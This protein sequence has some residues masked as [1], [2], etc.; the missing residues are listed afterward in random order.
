LKGAIILSER[1]KKAGDIPLW[2]DHL[3]ELSLKTPAGTFVLVGKDTPPILPQR[4]RKEKIPILNTFTLRVE[5][6]NYIYFDLIQGQGSNTSRYAAFLKSPKFPL[7][8]ET[9]CELYLYYTYGEAMPYNLQFRPKDTGSAGFASV[10]VQWLNKDANL[11]CQK[12][13]GG[14]QT[15]S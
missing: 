5:T 6:R 9:E 1:Q 4:G 11:S 8:R 15:L 2:K 3:L 10:E 7:K 12:D 14:I 13:L